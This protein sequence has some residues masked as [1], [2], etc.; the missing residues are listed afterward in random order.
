MW[1]ARERERDPGTTRCLN[2]VAGGEFS[3]DH[4][5]RCYTSRLQLW[6]YIHWRTEGRELCGGVCV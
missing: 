1:W 5:L 4:L 6:P 3:L 2:E